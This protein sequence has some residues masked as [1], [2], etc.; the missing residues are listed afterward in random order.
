MSASARDGVSGLLAWILWACA[1]RL[2]QQPSGRQLGGHRANDVFGNIVGDG[3]TAGAN[4]VEFLF[5]HFALT[6]KVI[7]K[8][9]GR[10]AVTSTAAL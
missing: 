4:F 10:R 6:E 8:R 3:L 1:G 5:G 7:R 2:C 9:N